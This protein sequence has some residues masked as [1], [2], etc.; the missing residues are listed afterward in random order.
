M[1]INRAKLLF[2]FLILFLLLGLMFYLIYTAGSVSFN[3]RITVRNRIKSD[4]IIQS[5]HQLESEIDGSDKRTEEKLSAGIDIML[6][7]VRALIDENGVYTGPRV[8][9]DGMIL[10]TEGDRV[11]FPDQFSDDFDYDAFYKNLDFYEV[12]DEKLD[13]APIDRAYLEQESTLMPAYHSANYPGEDNLSFITVRRAADDLWYL[14]VVS[15]EEYYEIL[16]DRTDMLD[17]INDLERSYNCFILLFSPEQ[18]G[19]DFS[20]ASERFLEIFP[21]IENASG[22]GIT[23]AELEKSGWTVTLGDETY[24]AAVRSL[25]LFRR[26]MKAVVLFDI[27]NEI[28]YIYN[29]IA[30]AVLL[31]AVFAAALILWLYWVR[32]YVQE[33]ALSEA[34]KKAYAPTRIRT[35]TTSLGLIGMI[36][37]FF[38]MLTYQSIG[39]LYMEVISD[40]DSLS[41]LVNRMSA[42]E[43]YSSKYRL[44]EESWDIYYARQ[45][46]S[47]LAVNEELWTRAFLFDV[48]EKIG[49]EYVMLFDEDGKEILSSNDYTRLSLGTDICGSCRGFR[50]LL[51]GDTDMVLQP[52]YD[53]VAEKTTQLIGVRAGMPGI[54]HYGALILAVDPELTWVAAEEKD[55]SSFMKSITPSENLSL[56]IDPEN[57]RVLYSSKES[58]EGLSIDS[59]GLEVSSVES[60][61]LDTYTI[62]DETYYGPLTSK[63]GRQFLYLSNGYI[64]QVNALP[65]ALV[66]AVCLMVI[67]LLIG[68][69]ML[70]R[71]TEKSYR[72]AVVDLGSARTNS[73]LDDSINNMWLKIQRI[74]DEDRSLRER[75]KLLLPENKVSIFVQVFSAIL[76]VVITVMI[77]DSDS[78]AARSA[79]G[80]ILRGNWKRGINLPAFAGVT[81]LI[82]SFI[83]FIFFKN[84]LMSILDNILD[85]KG[86]TIS[87]L[88]FSLLQYAAII[89]LV[90]YS[91]SFLGFNTT[92]LLASVSV[93][94]LAVSFGAQGLVADIISGIF[95]IFEDDFRVG[96]IIEVDGF[97]GI[98]QE[99]GVRSTKLIGIGDNVKIIGN[100]SVKNVLNM[101]KMN[102]WYSME[103][104]VPAD[105]PLDEI[106]EMLERELPVIG[107]AIPEIISG[108][109]YKGVMSIGENNTLYI[110]A[111]CQQE[112]YRRV[113]RELNH[114]IRMLFD[115]RGYKIRDAK[116]TE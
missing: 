58:Y 85:P 93:L 86:E 113:Q 53:N 81:I 87:R 43:D 96:D 77:V 37:I 61:D 99:I 62:S 79:I 39:S 115:Q 12:P 27:Q 102:S 42:S 106:E 64:L 116:T 52:E 95:I 50:K 101:S 29:C 75:W 83:I 5:L 45:I 30:V 57:R 11:L 68:S 55:F 84:L 14:D 32:R 54:E 21:D 31:T 66:S 94:S 69:F 2:A 109:Y 67:T 7:A 111:E 26:S 15:E 114:A 103:L 72:E 110:I 46:A 13:P 70:F 22:L 104:N 89:A 59:L 20:Y 88:A 25:N 38:V 74:D 23:E 91:F 80:F 16:S 17:S 9:S 105:Q 18:D 100:Q 36:V 35:V 24:M 47:L 28:N 92:A 34:Q 76:L 63:G 6:S 19:M 3:Q 56:V 4:S 51:L 44:D 98:V 60:L 78:M 90:F 73:L 48:N 112:Y 41:L 97:S 1:K 107:K 10:Q 33:H 108:P 8:F 65:M 49:G 71:Y 82:L 40:R